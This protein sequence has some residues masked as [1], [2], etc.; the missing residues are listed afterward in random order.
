VLRLF[1]SVFFVLVLGL[2]ALAFAQADPSTPDGEWLVLGRSALAARRYDEASSDLANASS[3]ITSDVEPGPLAAAW[4]DLGDA[5][6]LRGEPD[7]ALPAYGAS[8]LLVPT[9]ASVHVARGWAFAVRGDAGR[10]R[11]EIDLARRIAP[12]SADA[13][14]L[15]RE[16]DAIASL[17]M[18]LFVTGGVAIGVGVLLAAVSAIVGAVLRSAS[19]SPQDDTPYH[20]SIATGS[21]LAALGIA[22]ISVA[23]ALHV[24]SVQ[25]PSRSVSA[26]ATWLPG[27]AFAGVRTSF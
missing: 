24:G 17:R 9:S 4:A 5:F 14:A 21:V 13:L 18:S 2:P 12:G 22:T 25:L 7:R 3:S 11:G 15:E 10:A 6:V 19:A 20:W 27:G 16:L 1:S 26:T 23:D 8:L